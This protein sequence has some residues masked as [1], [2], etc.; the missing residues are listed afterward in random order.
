MIERVASG[1]FNFGFE[2]FRSRDTPYV[3]LKR[4]VA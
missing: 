2:E 4:D 3:G 1:S